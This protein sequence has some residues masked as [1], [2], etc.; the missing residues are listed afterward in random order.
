MVV[1][2]VVVLVV[3]VASR[4]GAG[5]GSHIRQSAEVALATKA[6]STAAVARAWPPLVRGALA[7]LPCGPCANPPKAGRGDADNATGR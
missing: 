2:V 1:L 7:C 6:P 3:V 4:G 5:R